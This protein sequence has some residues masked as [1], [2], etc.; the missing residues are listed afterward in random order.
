M[1]TVDISCRPREEG[2]I[3]R[4]QSLG[5][6]GLSVTRPSTYASQCIAWRYMG[7]CAER[8][9]RRASTPK[10]APMHG[11]GVIWSKN[12]TLLASHSGQPI[13]NS[14]ART[15]AVELWRLHWKGNLIENTA[16]M[17][18]HSTVGVHTSHVA[19]LAGRKYWKHR[20]HRDKAGVPLLQSCRPSSSSRSQSMR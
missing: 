5:L 15:T 4:K 3:T 11:V 13:T 8:Q 16:G 1:N 9:G 17:R 12:V 10:K 14:M 18:L 19:N 7:S 2:W 20:T 6:I